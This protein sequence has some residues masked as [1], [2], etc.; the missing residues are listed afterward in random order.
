MLAYLERRRCS[1]AAELA[2]EAIKRVWERVQTDPPENVGAFAYGVVRL[3]H[4][5]WLRKDARYKP[6]EDAEPAV[7]TFDPELQERKRRL[8][9]AIGTLSQSDKDFLAA[10]L[11][12][13]DGS[14]VLG[15]ALGLSPEAVRSRVFR[16]KERLRRLL[17]ETKL[18]GS[19]T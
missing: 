7:T 8:R 13:D 5:E 1:W 9:Q 12:C 15:K 4:L 18:T 3:V 2:D 11:M 10:Y 16:L 6:I 17:S 19:D 14:R